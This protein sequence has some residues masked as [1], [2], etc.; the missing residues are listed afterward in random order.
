MIVF[1]GESFAPWCEKARWALDHHRVTY[2]FVEHVPML[3]EL[4]LRIAAR[5]PTGPVTVPLLVD[6]EH[7][8]MDSLAI[9][10]HAEHHGAGAPLFPSEVDPEIVVW[11]QRSDALMRAG[12]ALLLHRMARDA[13]ALREQLPASVPRSATTLLTPLAA[14]AV[15]YLM[16]K[17]A[18]D[19]ADQASHEHACRE[20]LNQLRAACSHRRAYLVGS[21]LSYAD[22]TMAT[23]LQFILPVADDYVRL[24]AATRRAWTHPTLHLAYPDLLAWR[25]ELYARHR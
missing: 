3:G 16:A 7:R 24:G 13:A 18:T 14:L 21:T 25:D 12:R 15:R 20:V 19:V 5:R 10:R 23:A 11:D 17:Y 4:S 6:G 9:A 22:L 2:R 8:V 1:Y